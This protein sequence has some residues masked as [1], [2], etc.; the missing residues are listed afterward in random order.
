MSF[1]QNFLKFFKPTSSATE[2][3]SY[4]FWVQC[5]HCGEEIM[6]RIDLRNDLSIE[7]DDSGRLES[8]VCRKIIMGSGENHCFQQIE[9]NFRL[10]PNRRITEKTI[11]GGKFLEQE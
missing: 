2:D 8:Y 6:G 4:R 5:Q 1:L 7:Y 11:Q 10:D 9:V 3:Y